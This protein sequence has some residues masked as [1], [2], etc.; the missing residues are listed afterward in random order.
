MSKEKKDQTPLEKAKSLKSKRAPKAK[1]TK[2]E[3]EVYI[4]WFEGD[5]DTTQACHGL[6]DMSPATFRTK[7]GSVLRDAIIR[8]DYEIS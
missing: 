2:E 5:I 3:M 1:L 6:N 4:A 7:C 8:G